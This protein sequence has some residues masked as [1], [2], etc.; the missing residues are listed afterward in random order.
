MPLLPVRGRRILVRKPQCW[1][2]STASI[3]AW[4]LSAGRSLSNR[5]ICFVRRIAGGLLAFFVLTGTFLILPVY[6]APAPQAT[7]VAPSIDAVDMGSVDQPT[8]AAVV[9]DDGAVVDAGP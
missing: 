8:D 9:I 6:A 7:P 3:R 1:T 4:P 2:V 5:R